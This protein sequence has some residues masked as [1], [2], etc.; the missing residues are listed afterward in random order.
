MT[1]QELLGKIK[2]D[3]FL[4]ETHSF[5]DAVYILGDYMVSGNFVNGLRTVDHRDLLED[6]CTWQ[7]LLH[8]GTVLVPEMH[9]AIGQKHKDL[10]RKYGYRMLPVGKKNHIVGC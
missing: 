1:K 5:S 8:Y 4:H 2:A 9:T 3:E 7:E 6:D 10:C